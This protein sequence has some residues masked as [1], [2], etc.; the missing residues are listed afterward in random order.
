[1]T[2][3]N[4]TISEKNDIVIRSYSQSRVKF[5]WIPINQ[6]KSVGSSTAF[7]HRGRQNQHRMSLLAALSKSHN[8]SKYFKS[9]SLTLRL[10]FNVKLEPV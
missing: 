7:V 1:M 3:I 2:Y 9:D 6:I 5:G 8:T 4:K 10:Y